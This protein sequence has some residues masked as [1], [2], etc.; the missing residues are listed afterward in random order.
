[1]PE[2][3]RAL[4]LSQRD[5][6]DTA[7]AARAVLADASRRD[8]VSCMAA[9]LRERVG[10]HLTGA[11]TSS[12]FSGDVRGAAEPLLAFVASSDAIAEWHVQHGI[13][14]DVT[15]ATLGDL[16]R[17]VASFRTGHGRVGLDLP[18]PLLPHW[19]GSL[20][21]LGRLQFDLQAVK[22]GRR[23]VGLPAPLHDEKWLLSISVPDSGPLTGR[24]VDAS[25]ASARGFFSAHFPDAAPRFAHCT[26]WLLDPHLASVLPHE[27][28][29]VRFQRR[30]T[31]FGGPAPGDDD[32]VWFACGHRRL[33]DLADLASLPRD[34][35]LR[36]A[37]VSRIEAGGHWEIRQGYL[38]LPPS[39]A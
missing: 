37:V 26:S 33:A 23:S 39:P 28:H 34:T 22:P 11:A 25:L 31:L 5:A 15:R 17:H 35:T 19:Q 6:V 32:A 12:P 16:G 24:A 2:R 10:G 9:R 29:V 36:R 3:L 4:G 7:T 38:E 30:F 27:A 14:D 13:P 18:Q 8:A 21:S 1:M 20:Y